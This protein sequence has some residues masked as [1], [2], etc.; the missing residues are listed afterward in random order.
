[1]KSFKEISKNQSGEEIAESLVFPGT[2]SLKDEHKAAFIK[3]FREHRRKVAA[4]YSEKTR[5]ISK[6]LELKFKIEDYI[7]SSN[8]NENLYF[9]YFLNEYISRLDKK[10]KDFA[11][12]IEID[13]TEISQIINKHRKPTDKL[14]FRLEIHSNRNFPALLWFKILEKERAFELNNN[15]HIIEEEGVHVKEKLE[16]SF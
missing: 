10:K 6:L 14:I 4:Q 8:F 7:E 5:L 13:P 12:E 16:F 11:H 2:S 3:E 15:R 9:G 1:M